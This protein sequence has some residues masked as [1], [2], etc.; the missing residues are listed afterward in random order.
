MLCVEDVL[1]MHMALSSISSQH[2]SGSHRQELS[3]MLKE[4]LSFI[5]S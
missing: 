4:Y 3:C 2:Q 5:L 1:S